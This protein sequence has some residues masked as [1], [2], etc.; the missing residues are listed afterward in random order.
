M[1]EKNISGIDIE[2][3]KEIMKDEDLIDKKLQRD[4][5]KAKHR[6]RRLKLKEEK[7]KQKESRNP[8][9]KLEKEGSDD[10]FYDR[11]DKLIDEL[12]DPD[13]VYDK[14]N[15]YSSNDDS[16]NQDYD[17]FNQIQEE[18][19]QDEEEEETEEQE[20]YERQVTKKRKIGTKIDTKFKKLK[21]K[22]LDL[23]DYETLAMHL[24]NN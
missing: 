15:D 7:R 20:E 11:T 16:D 6:E 9:I 24:L 4:L 10:D 22:E 21:E 14:Q 19:E 2:I 1:E 17:Q 3:A 8:S 5:V 12:P 13:A 23:A 18:E